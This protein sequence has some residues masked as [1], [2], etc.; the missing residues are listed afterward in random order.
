LRQEK[1]PQLVWLE[2]LPHP[3]LGEVAKIFASSLFVNQ[4]V[5]LQLLE[6]EEEFHQQV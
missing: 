1:D 2:P 3:Q 4:Q 6:L 5:V